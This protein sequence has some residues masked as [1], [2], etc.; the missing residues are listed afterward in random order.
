MS[1]HTISG[2]AIVT[3]ASGFVGSHLRDALIDASVDVVTLRR[4][5]SPPTSQGRSAEI[6]YANPDSLAR[7]FEIEKPDY[8][9]HVAG[10]MNG[11][12]YDDFYQGNVV[13]TRN[14]IQALRANNSQ[15]RRFVYVSSLTSYGPA[16]KG[17]PLREDDEPRPV[18]FYGKSKLEAE[19]AVQAIGNAVPWTII[20]PGGIYGP[21]DFQYLELCRFIAKGISPFYGNRQ[22][23]MSIVHIDDLINAIITAAQSPATLYKGYFIGDGRPVTWEELQKLIVKAAGRRVWEVDVPGFIFPLVG[24]GGEIKARI[25][26]KPS[27]YN[28]QKV[29]MGIQDA[30]TGR[31]DSAREDFGY[32]PRIS[33]EDGMRSTFEWYRSKKWL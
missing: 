31:H 11:I 21:G 13:P 4:A 1:E 28:R 10:V 29:I 17:V 33:L 20:R 25:T 7:V 18:E 8:V 22:R 6:D 15:L 32:Q 16:R 12:H 19:R 14:L 30:W 23:E 2:K 5:G 3:G 24:L 9:F 26:G 27:L